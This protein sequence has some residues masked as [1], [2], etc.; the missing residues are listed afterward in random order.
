V[1]TL[2]SDPMEQSKILGLM[3]ADRFTTSHCAYRQRSQVGRHSNRKPNE[4]TPLKTRVGDAGSK[5]SG[6]K[7]YYR[8]PSEA[9]SPGTAVQPNLRAAPAQYLTDSSPEATIFG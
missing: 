9:I 3:L 6:R 1:L 5:I 2:Y 7:H 4:T 8:T